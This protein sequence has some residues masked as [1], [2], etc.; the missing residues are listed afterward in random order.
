VQ[1]KGNEEGVMRNRMAGLTIQQIDQRSEYQEQ[2]EW[3][4]GDIGKEC[5]ES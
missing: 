2:T 1:W 3:R 5:E 4:E